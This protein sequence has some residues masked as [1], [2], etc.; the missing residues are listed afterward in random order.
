VRSIAL[1]LIRAVLSFR[2]SLALLLTTALLALSGQ[3]AAAAAPAPATVLI[4][5]TA[6][7]TVLP[8]GAASKLTVT[9]SPV[10]HTG[11]LEIFEPQTGAWLNSCFPDVACS[12]N[13]T[14]STPAVV[15]Y[16]AFWTSQ[17]NHDINQINILGSSNQ[18]R[19]AWGT[20][21]LGAP[22]ASPV[23]VGTDVTL[24]ATTSFDVGPTPDFIKLFDV[25][26]NAYVTP[27]CPF[28]TTC[29]WH[30][31]QAAAGT[32]LY[33]ALVAPVTDGIPPVFDIRSSSQS[34]QWT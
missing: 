17:D 11:I 15:V 16:Q 22:S 5:L 34:A 7:R 2:A 31:S 19:V 25:T 14:R 10:L 20:V 33:I 12:I 28:G 29:T 30:V 8:L 3:S 9:T 26:A 4:T 21:S 27:K 24:T 13:V 1:S 18:V 23:P 6:S 32:H